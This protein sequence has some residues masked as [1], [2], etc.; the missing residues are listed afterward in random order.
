MIY[1]KS[2]YGNL[3]GKRKKEPMKTTTID[4][5]LS[6]EITARPLDKKGFNKHFI[7]LV[8]ADVFK[9]AKPSFF[10]KLKNFFR[11]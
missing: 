1:K 4:F 3:F 11:K 6:R 9:P 2:K 10:N 7:N 8:S 5:E